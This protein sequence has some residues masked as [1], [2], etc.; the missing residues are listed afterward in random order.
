MGKSG[1]NRK[2]HRKGDGSGVG[3]GNRTNRPILGRLDIKMNLSLLDRVKVDGR[4][5]FSVKNGKKVLG[6]TGS[7]RF[8][9]MSKEMKLKYCIPK[10]LSIGKS[11]VKSSVKL[12]D[13]SCEEDTDEDEDESC[14]EDD[15]QVVV[16]TIKIANFLQLYNE[17]KFSPEFFYIGI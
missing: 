15:T 6:H 1:S 17:E 5:R 11:S 7:T 16:K 13:E 9:R 14:E 8:D 4:V 10:E 2:S 3:S 12:C